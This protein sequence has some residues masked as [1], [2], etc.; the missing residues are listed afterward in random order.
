MVKV[1]FS[2]HPD[3]KKALENRHPVL[4]L[5]STILA[6]GMPFPDNYKFAKMADKIALDLGVVPATI[7][8]L[9]GEIKIGLNKE[10]LEF[11]CKENSVIKTSLSDLSVTVAGGEIW[12][13]H[14]IRNDAFGFFVGC[15]CFFH[16]GHWGRPPLL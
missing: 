2:I 13:N 3:V 7:A 9:N 6:H 1:S 15:S 10:D 16:R 8:I 5:E 12:S 14:S 4:A 11:I